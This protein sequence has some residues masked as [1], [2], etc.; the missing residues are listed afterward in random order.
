MAKTSGSTRT[1]SPGAKGGV[2]GKDT[3][4]K[5]KIKAVGG[6]R[7]IEDNVARRAVQS[8][9]SQ[10]Y[11][12]YGL[13]TRNVKTAILDYSVVGIGGAGGITLNRQYYNDAKKLMAAKKSAYASKWSVR[14]NSPLRHTVIHELA[15]A[16]W[17]DGRSNLSPKLTEGIRALY[18]RFKVGVRR[19]QNPIGTYAAS[20]INEF[21]AEGITQATI[22][23]K[24]S[25]YSVRLKKLLKRY[26]R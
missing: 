20:N 18:K 17:Q 19:G 11:N 14:T 21:W 15:H 13:P 22:G 7:D 24:Q 16:H 23:T 12:D 3:N 5:G 8:A 25:Y 10:F 9:V 6:I 4:Y 26:G 1:K 2:E